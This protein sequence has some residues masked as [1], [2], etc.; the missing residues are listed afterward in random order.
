MEIVE[1]QEKIRKE[2]YEI[3][4][5]AEK[6]RYVEGITIHDLEMAIYNVRYWKIILMTH[7]GQVV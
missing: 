7:E 5:H 3:S 2:E 1:I 4:F 6:E